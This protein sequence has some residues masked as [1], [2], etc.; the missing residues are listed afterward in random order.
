MAVISRMALL[1]LL[2]LIPVGALTVCCKSPSKGKSA[3]MRFFMNSTVDTFEEYDSDRICKYTI[4]Y[5]G[6]R[7]SV[8]AIVA[9]SVR[10]PTPAS[11]IREDDLLLLAVCGC[12]EFARGQ[13]STEIEVMFCELQWPNLVSIKPGTEVVVVLGDRNEFVRLER[14]PTILQGACLPCDFP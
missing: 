12:E 7:R 8:S 6:S 13:W 9:R 11:I 14:D 3:D 5:K 4:V 2:C 1:I 10:R